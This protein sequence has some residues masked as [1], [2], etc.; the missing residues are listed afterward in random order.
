MKSI[1]QIIQT[2]QAE[3]VLPDGATEPVQ[4]TRPWP[5]VVLTAIGAWFAAFPLMMMIQLLLGDLLRQGAGAYAVGLLVL[6][7][8]V[9]I[10]RSGNV[11]LFVEQL[12]VPTLLVGGATLA[13]GLFHDLTTASAAIVLALITLA[14]AL[15]APRA[16]LRVLLGMLACGLTV[17]A[18]LPESRTWAGASVMNQFWLGWHLSLSVWLACHWALAKHLNSGKTARM[19]IALDAISTGW[20]L[21]TLIGLS[22]WSGMTFMV[23][24]TLNVGGGAHAVV[25]LAATWSDTAIRVCSLLLALGAAGLIAM[26]WTGLQRLWCAGAA[27]IVAGLAWQLPALGAAVFV[28]AFCAS[29]GRMKMACAAALAAA[30]I[31]GSYYYQLDYP[32]DVK[33]L[34]LVAAGALLGLLAWIGAGKGLISMEKPSATPSRGGIAV[35]VGAVLVLAVAN[36]AIWQK[37]NLIANGSVVYVE[38]APLDPRSLLQGDF[39]RLNYQL[40]IDEKTRALSPLGATRPHVVASRDTRGIAKLLRI[41]DGNAL[42]ANEFLIELTPRTGGWMLVSDAWYFREGEAKRW[43]NAKYGEFRVT[44]DGRALLVGLRGAN[45]EK[46]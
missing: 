13:S 19:A 38:L 17:L 23:G 40:P 32:L 41:H 37:E 14:I 6:G 43:E 16:W 27:L 12:A 29:S 42:P 15:V 22:F 34:R 9:T 28:I 20:I 36:G 21:A 1:A 10:L 39:M 33:A 25:P 7:A 4:E 2:A 5:V 24:A 11:S 44:S 30:W 3:G 26:K 18:T 46:L 8:S 45:L 31:I 35:A